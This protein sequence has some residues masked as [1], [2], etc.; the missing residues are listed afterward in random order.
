MSLLFLFC[1]LWVL[2]LLFV[3]NMIFQEDTESFLSAKAWEEEAFDRDG[4]RFIAFFYIQESA[5]K[6]VKL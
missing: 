6:E 1:H 5:D 2:S 4:L 3:S